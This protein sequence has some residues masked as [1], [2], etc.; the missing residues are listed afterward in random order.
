MGIGCKTLQ[1]QRKFDTWDINMQKYDDF[2][3]QETH[4][5]MASL[6]TLDTIA[7]RYLHYGSFFG[8]NAV[9]NNKKIAF[10]QKNGAKA[11]G[12]VI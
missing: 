5:N 11:G 3:T 4:G 8:E 9:H 7:P 1:Q 10:N 6:A 12:V 2:C